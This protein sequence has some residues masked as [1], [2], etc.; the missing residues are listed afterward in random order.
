MM[1][2]FRG[3]I[4]IPDEPVTLDPRRITGKE[5]LLGMYSSYTELDLPTVGGIMDAIPARQLNCSVVQS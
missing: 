2:G 4:F 5:R 1:Q 3:I